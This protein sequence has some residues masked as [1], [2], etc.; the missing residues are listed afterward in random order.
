MQKFSG[1]DKLS[2]L[3]ERAILE[4]LSPDGKTHAEIAQTLNIS[5]R[6]IYNWLSLPEFRKRLLQERNKIREEALEGLKTILSKAV[7]KL[8]S[9]L[10]AKSDGVKLR[11]AQTILDFNLR[12]K[13]AQELEERV[14]ELE[15][16][17]TEG[18]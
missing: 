15:R 1:D 18:K 9:L 3:Q 11:S 16:K 17:L 14:S 4:L 8:E 13:E 10:G 12:L 6:T 5:E 2:R 7:K